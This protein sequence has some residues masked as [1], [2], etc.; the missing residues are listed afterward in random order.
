MLGVRG[1]GVPAGGHL[2]LGEAVPRAAHEDSRRARR[3]RRGASSGPGGSVLGFLRLNGPFGGG[4]AP[5]KGGW[6]WPLA[7][8]PRARRRE[9]RAKTPRQVVDPGG[10]AGRR[11]APW[12]RVTPPWASLRDGAASVPLSQ[13]SVASVSPRT[14]CP[15]LGDPRPVEGQ[16][17]GPRG[18]P[19]SRAGRAPGGRRRRSGRRG[20]S[21]RREPS[22]DRAWWRSRGPC[23]A[24]SRRSTAAR[25]GRRG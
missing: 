8:P 25:P 19:I 14:T 4:A 20:R 10:A 5:G 13:A 11:S 24:T 7:R 9:D 6:H 12:L 17:T 23:T 15:G 18:R 1:G 16:A 2:A 22:R 3:A 21:R